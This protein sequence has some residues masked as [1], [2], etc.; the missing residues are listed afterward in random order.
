MKTIPTLFFLVSFQV[1]S[2]LFASDGSNYLKTAEGLMPG[3][4][5]EIIPE[6]SPK[7]LRAQ[8][9]KKE[10]GSSA[11]PN[12][13]QTSSPMVDEV[14]VEGEKIFVFGYRDKSNAVTKANCLSCQRESSLH[15]VF[16]KNDNGKFDLLLDE[17]VGSGSYAG[18]PWITK[19]QFSDGNKSKDV[20]LI[21]VALGSAMNGE[22][23]VFGYDTKN[24][25][26]SEIGKL[27]GTQLKYV[28]LKNDKKI[29][30]IG[31]AGYLPRFYQ[32]INGT[33]VDCSSEHKDLYESY[34]SEYLGIL[35]TMNK[36][37]FAYYSDVKKLL[38]T[39]Y[40]KAGEKEAAQQATNELI[41]D[42]QLEISRLKDKKAPAFVIHAREVE[43]NTLE[44]NL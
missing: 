19:S 24:L 44:K 39:A 40:G 38:I 13:N 28:D 21:N 35:T 23:L 32:L 14:I 41:S 11:S 1:V 37:N 30:S 34:V 20:L 9:K 43:L 4:I 5:V 2:F 12:I 16:Y 15:I 3:K 33:L 6:T 36:K 10:E 42:Y 7:S 22:Y 17:Q 31:D 8:I 18:K 25:S 27:Y 26:F 29:I